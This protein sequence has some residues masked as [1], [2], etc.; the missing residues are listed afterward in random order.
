M[1]TVKAALSEELE[2]LALAGWTA[3][4]IAVYYNCSVGT[5][6][7]YARQF[8]LVLTREK[9]HGQLHLKHLLTATFP[10][11]RLE[12]EYGIGERLRLDFYLPELQLAFEFDGSQHEEFSSYFHGDEE[13]FR[14][15][16]QRDRRKEEF[17]ALMGIRLIRVKPGESLDPEALRDLALEHLAQESATDHNQRLPEPQPPKHRSFILSSPAYKAA[18][19]QCRRENY[20]RQKEQLKK[21]AKARIAATAH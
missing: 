5:V 16:Q 7:R 4:E 1:P 20:K 12:E 9:S 14:A 11:Y 3:G 13:E 10:G 8:G 6:Q 21:N 19:R 2:S 17:C 18:A 15:A